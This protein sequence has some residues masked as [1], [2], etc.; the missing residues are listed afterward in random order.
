LKPSYR[1]YDYEFERYWHFFQVFGR[2]GYNPATPAEVWQREFQRR[3]GKDAAPYVE[4][5]L[6]RAS[7]VLPRIVASCY[8]YGY[9]P[10]T[11][12]WAEKQRLGDLPDY[13]M[14]EGSDVQQF[15]SFDEEARN[16]LE[17]IE[18]AKTR[19]P[20]TSRWFA[21]A[22][23]DIVEN[24]A[25]A[26][27]H[28]GSHRNKEF[29]S[30][31]VDL[32]VLA[33]LASF[34][35]RR[36]PA[37]VSYCTY[38]RTKDVAALDDAMAH[39]QSAIAAWRQLVA[40]AGDVYADDLMMGARSAALCGHWKD[41][42]AALEKG[43]AALQRQRSQ[44]P[45]V[46]VVHQELASKHVAPATTAGG[47]APVVVSSPIAAAKAGKPL[48]ITAEV[49][50]PSGVKWVRVRFR[51]VTQFEDFQTRPMLPTG[52]KDQYQVVIPAEQVVPQWDFMYLI[53]VMDN[54]GRGHIYPDLNKETPYVVVRLVR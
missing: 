51:S 36:I 53:E 4:K 52:K 28:V 46:H 21:R 48:T 17:G 40:A 30:T 44:L 38:K 33:N 54:Q 22:A 43:F 8:P 32:K 5:G 13:A 25:E 50:S 9:F 47:E 34:H 12:G 11:R 1:Y 23:A 16:L 14:A 41:E 20:E 49:R 24:V 10:M 15:A 6:H 7:W 31:M 42:L 26:E 35:A 39:E 19:P 27:R 29:D 2:I 45:S 3:F 37:A 18:T